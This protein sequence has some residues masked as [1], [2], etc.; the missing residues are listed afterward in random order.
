MNL[1]AQSMTGKIGAS[2][3]ARLQTA[4]IGL[5]GAGGLGS[6]CAMHLVRSGFCHLVL[7]DF[8]HVEA[9]NLNR[10]FFFPAQTGLPKVEALAQNLLQI[11]PD[12]E[13]TLVQEKLTADNARHIFSGCD[14]VVECLDEAAA[15]AMLA[16]QFFPQP[17]LYVAASGI[18]GIGTAQGMRVKKLRDTVYIVGDGTSEVS[19]DC[20]PC[21]P[22]VGAAAAMQ[23][24]LVLSYFLTGAHE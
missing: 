5:A 2:R 24:D 23:A 16:Q 3:L 1:I 22:A 9:S 19:V 15:K 7:C 13:L 11:N 4:K 21:S 18:G 10:Q 8:D 14:A 20:P 17:T 12:L 6:N